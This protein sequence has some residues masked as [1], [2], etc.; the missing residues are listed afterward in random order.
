MHRLFDMDSPLM[1]GLGKIYDCLMLSVCW[2]LASAPIVTMGAACGALYRTVFY[3]FRREEGTPLKTFWK[4]W[5]TNLKHGIVCWLPV[6]AL[7]AFLIADVAI[8]R[9]LA[10]AGKPMAQLYGIVLVLLG[11]AGVWAAYVTSYCVR[12]EGRL[13]DVLWLSAY[14]VLA[15]PLMSAVIFLFLA[16][17]VAL[18]LMVPFLL[19]FLPAAVCLAISFP[20]ET[21]YRKHMQPQ[22]IEKLDS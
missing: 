4:T 21:V 3:C 6:L 20:M 16:G 19:L 9:G 15:H 13:K 12:F 10:G 1:N 7:Y 2:L 5:R 8:L 22:D 17:G 14:L 18:S 11:V